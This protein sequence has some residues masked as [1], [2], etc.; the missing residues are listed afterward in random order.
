MLPRLSKLE[1][2]QREGASGAVEAALA[3]V[4][5]AERRARWPV[6][7]PPCAPGRVPADQRVDH[8]RGVSFGTALA[9][10]EMQ[11]RLAAV[12]R[13]LGVCAAAHG[14]GGLHVAGA[15]AQEIPAPQRDDVAP[16]FVARGPGP[17]RL[18]V[19]R[20]AR[21]SGRARR[22]FCVR[23]QPRPGNFAQ[24]CGCAVRLA[25]RV[26]ASAGS[27]GANEGGGA[28]AAVACLVGE[29]PAEVAAGSGGRGDRFL[30]P[31]WRVH[32]KILVV[33]VAGVVADADAAAVVDDGVVIARLRAGKGLAPG[34]AEQQAGGGSGARAWGPARPHLGILC[35]PAAA[36]V[37]L[38]GPRRS[39]ATAA[40]PAARRS[41]RVRNP[42]PSPSTNFKLPGGMRMRGCRELSALRVGGCVRACEH[43]GF[44]AVAVGT[45]SPQRCA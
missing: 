9:H 21:P 15:A 10:V 11:E 39:R 44:V 25:A 23:A 32:H 28:D 36:Y 5:V 24:R 1:R 40:Q 35:G 17:D 31:L 27:A 19:K 7:A 30:W 14:R 12:A 33:F 34:Q 22:D 38:P 45:G 18:R 42:Y 37:G 4:S 20:A 2:P 41:V 3:V 26:V 6:H 13:R 8:V 16:A 43:A 29:P